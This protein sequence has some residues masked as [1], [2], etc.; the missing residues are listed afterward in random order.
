MGAYDD[1][2]VHFCQLLCISNVQNVATLGIAGLSF[3]SL[4]L[5]C[6]ASRRL[7]LLLPDRTCVLY[8][9]DC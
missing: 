1:E 4:C 2:A 9:S 6:S 5:V 7:Q 3:S 8:G